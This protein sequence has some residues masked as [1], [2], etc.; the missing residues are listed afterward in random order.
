MTPDSDAFPTYVVAGSARQATAWAVG[1]NWYLN[2]NFKLNL[3]Y[4]TTSFENGSGTPGTVTSRD[5][6]VVL[7]QA[8]IAF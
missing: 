4:E 1:L 8:Q 7:T 3:N 5:E 2:R 6:R